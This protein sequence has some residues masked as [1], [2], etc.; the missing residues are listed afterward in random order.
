MLLDLENYKRPNKKEAQNY[1]RRIDEDLVLK[2]NECAEENKVYP[3]VVMRY[4]IDWS[5][6]KVERE[7]EYRNHMIEITLNRNSDCKKIQKIFV[8]GKELDDKMQKTRNK[9]RLYN[10]SYF[11]NES[12][13]IFFKEN[14]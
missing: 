9:Y 13:R 8:L 7:E 10:L 2:I 5:C 12:I 4:I 11:I 3:S 1:T 6:D 14:K